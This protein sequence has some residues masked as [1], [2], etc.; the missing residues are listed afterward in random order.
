MPNFIHS[1]DASNIHI[2]IKNIQKYLPKQNINLYTIHDC[3]ASDQKNIG[4]IELLVKHSFIE[5]YFKHNYLNKIHDS[6]IDQIKEN[7]E[8]FEETVIINNKSV[9]QNYLLLLN[10]KS[11]LEK[12]IIPE[13]PQYN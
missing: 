6:F 4:L 1:L 7:N 8:I 11:N 5:L 13:L 12:I 10:N 2:L 9:K 3:L